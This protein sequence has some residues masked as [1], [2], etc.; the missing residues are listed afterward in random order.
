[1]RNRLLPLFVFSLILKLF[2]SHLVFAWVILSALW[3]YTY[4]SRTL[5]L[6]WLSFITWSFPF[7]SA[8]A[9]E[10]N[11]GKVIEVKQNSV[12]IENNGT[13]VLVTNCEGCIFGDYIEV[14]GKIKPIRSAPTTYGF[15]FG[16]WANQEEIDFS[17]YAEKTVVHKKTKEWRGVI[18]NKLLEIEDQSTRTLLIK[19]I[20]NIHQK[21]TEFPFLSQLGFGLYGFLLVMRKMLSYIVYRKHAQRI[22]FL[23][24]IIA[25]VF[26]QGSFIPFRLV[27]GRLI[28]FLPIESKDK[29]GLFGFLC[30][31]FFPNKLFTI[32]FLIPFGLRLIGQLRIT[33][34]RIVTYNYIAV[35]QSFFFNQVQGTML[36]L[37]PIILRVSGIFYCLAWIQVFLPFL[38]FMA[39]FEIWIEWLSKVPSVSLV[40]N[41][42]GWGL[43]G[44]ILLQILQQKRKASYFLITF[45]LFLKFGLF[46]PL[47][48]ITI[49]QVGQG[50]SI[51]IHSIFNRY[52]VIIDTGKKSQYPQLQAALQARGISRIDA[53]FL[54]HDDEDHSGGIELLKEEFNVKQVIVEHRDYDI[55]GLFMYSINSSTQGEDNDNSLVHLMQINGIRILLTGDI[56]E[57]VERKL[58]QQIPELDVDILK[59][60]HHGSKTSSSLVFLDKTSPNLVLISS[61]IGNSFR[62]PSKEVMER[63]ENLGINWL[64]TQEDGDISLYF[65][66]F[67]N[68]ITTSSKKIGIMDRVIK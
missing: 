43:L 3:L 8:Q 42:M 60:A 65:T 13:R 5:I 2:D 14:K 44:F 47:T 21:E 38:N 40:G 25:W 9:Q 19:L 58:I 15:D 20:F 27:I 35:L 33:S 67:L 16:N 62:H 53:V 31:L 49:I 56:S 29:V 59:L 17:I 30:W 68:F 23:L 11:H 46:H 57:K 61:G 54:T 51:L 6:L 45:L 39:V 4:E 10:I 22:E 18:Y 50:E 64:D 66:P 24:S 48:E 28:G 55:N 41:W 52:T 26:Y 32:G 1:M 34:K 7:Q 12:V 37:Y 63:V 36:L